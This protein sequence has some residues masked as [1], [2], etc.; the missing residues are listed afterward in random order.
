MTRSIRAGHNIV[1][2]MGMVGLLTATAC[3]PKRLAEMTIQETHRC[4]RPVS[5]GSI[6]CCAKAIETG[7]ECE[8]YYGLNILSNGYLPVQVSIR[9]DGEKAVSLKLADFALLQSDGTSAQAVSPDAVY[10]DL[11][12]SVGGRT[13]GW[14]VLFGVIG[15]V[16]AY[17]A[18]KNRNEAL[19]SSLHTRPFL[20]QSIPPSQETSGVVYFKLTRDLEKR[21]AHSKMNLAG[22]TL[23]ITPAIENVNEPV[24]LAIDLS[25]EGGPAPAAGAWQK[26]A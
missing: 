25:S 13:L 22:I 1:A 2:V 12:A 14:G 7:S 15:G 17:S 11:K 20:D 9:N 16:A 23:R 19:G 8:S 21:V 5:S 6:T 24:P 4:A 3:G 10:S 26:A 18:A